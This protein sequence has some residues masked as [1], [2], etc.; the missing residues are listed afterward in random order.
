MGNEDGAK[1]RP[2]VVIIALADGQVAVVPIT[3]APP[4][5][6]TA[7]VEL[8]SATCAGLGLDDERSWVVVDE[9]NRFRW[10]GP[11]LRPVRSG[12]WAFGTL[13]RGDLLRVAAGVR[14]AVTAR[15]ISQTERSE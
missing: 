6:G 11:D 4:S 3:H 12:K 9:V 8:T 7:A 1:D 13:P 10:P 15:R 5:E 14:D 2:C